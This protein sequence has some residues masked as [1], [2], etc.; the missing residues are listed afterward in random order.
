MCAAGAFRGAHGYRPR[1]PQPGAVPGRSEDREAAA[2]LR[3]EVAD[4]ET[5]LAGANDCNIEI[6][7]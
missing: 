5:C 1:Q 4:R 6:I 3:E 7:C 2:L